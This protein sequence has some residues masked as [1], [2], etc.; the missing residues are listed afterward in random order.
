MLAVQALDSEPLRDLLSWLP[1][2]LDEDLCVPVLA[3]RLNLSDRQFRRVF[4]AQVG[5]IA[6]DHVEA[7][8]LEARAGFWRPRRVLSAKSPSSAASARRRR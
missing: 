8:R 3:R 1:E 7:V 5:V 6:A 4:K 2:R